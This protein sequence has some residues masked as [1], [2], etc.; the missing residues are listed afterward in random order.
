MTEDNLSEYELALEIVY[1]KAKGKL[2]VLIDKPSTND[3][4]FK[5]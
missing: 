5:R 3:K 4:S 2:I 1:A